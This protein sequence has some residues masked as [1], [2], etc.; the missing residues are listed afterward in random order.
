ALA[1][2]IAMHIAASKPNCVSADQMP[3]DLIEKEREIFMAQAADSGKPADIIAKMVDG[4]ITKF[5]KENTLEGQPF[6]KDPEQTVGQLL[7][8]AK[9]KVISFQ[10]YVV[11]EGIE[12]A[13]DNFAEE[14][15]AQVRGN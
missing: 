5:L 15:M 4:R 6:V 13:V 2:D 9:A 11:G 12:K 10:R 8:A 1:K 7:K 14:V 3:A